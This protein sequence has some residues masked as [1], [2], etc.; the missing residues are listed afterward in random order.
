MDS[1]E[2]P[3]SNFPNRQIS[4]VFWRPCSIWSSS[5]TWWASAPCWPTRLWRRASCCSGTS[6]TALRWSKPRN[7]STL[8][9]SLNFSTSNESN[10]L[11][12][13]P[14]TSPLGER[15]PLVSDRA[16]KINCLLAAVITDNYLVLQYFS[17]RELARCW[18]SPRRK[19]WRWKD[20]PSHWWPSLLHSACSILWSLGCSPRPAPSFSLGYV[21]KILL[22]F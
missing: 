17:R 3:R 8:D 21:E 18:N 9:F 4:Q 6:P 2:P 13:S 11:R 7:T 5:W 15:W 1:M 20:G 16:D 10:R 12:S 14:A 22:R 19:W